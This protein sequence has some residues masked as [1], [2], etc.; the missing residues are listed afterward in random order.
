MKEEEI[1]E[2]LEKELKAL[3]QKRT[4]INRKIE[5]KSK[6]LNSC[7]ARMA[8]KANK[9]KAYLIERVIKVVCDHFNTK[10]DILT[11]KTS[12]REIVLARKFLSYFLYHKAFLTQKQI[13]YILNIGTESNICMY[14]KRVS[15]LILFDKEY[16]KHYNL[17]I[18]ELD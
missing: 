10:L 8:I 13:K 17:I 6:D 2:S 9:H 12:K 18:N 7:K 11:L 4:L 14:N 3:K 15:E 1:K 16:N 5:E